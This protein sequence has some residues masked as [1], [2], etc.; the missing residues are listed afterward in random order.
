MTPVSAV[1]EILSEAFPGVYVSVEVPNDTTIWPANGRPDRFLVVQRLGGP[2]GYGV[3]RA[4]MVVQCYSLD[5]AQAE[6]DAISADDALTASPNHRDDVSR[7]VNSSLADFPDPEIPGS[8][9][10][11]TGHL[12]TRPHN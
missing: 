4:L 2:R 12:E 6:E 5:S 11:V 8:R 10:Q 9:Y 1:V 3:D 7:W